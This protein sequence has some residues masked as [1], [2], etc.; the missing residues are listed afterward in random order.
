VVDLAAG[1][2]QGKVDEGAWGQV[3]KSST[4]LTL[5]TGGTCRAR[6]PDEGAMG[7]GGILGLNLKTSQEH[8]LH[9]QEGH[10][11]G[12]VNSG[13]GMVQGQG[14]DVELHM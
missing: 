12:R 10:D 2:L 6:L 4:G 9:S 8:S 7:A 1:C 13:V 5:Q 3:G 14:R 11:E